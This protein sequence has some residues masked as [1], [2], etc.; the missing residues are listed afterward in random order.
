MVPEIAQRGPSTPMGRATSMKPHQSSWVASRM[1]NAKLSA[2]S[3]EN[4]G[5]SI[6][7]NLKIGVFLEKN[8]KIA[9]FYWR[10]CPSWEQNQADL[11]ATDCLSSDYIFYRTHKAPQRGPVTPANW[12][13]ACDFRFTVTECHFCNDASRYC[14]AKINLL[15]QN[16]ANL[17]LFDWVKQLSLINEDWSKSPSQM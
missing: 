12:S 15:F 5:A 1:S 8:W 11:R 7:K 16:W 9:G 3:A 6:D 13:M 2:C 17:A 4:F 10:I 14:I